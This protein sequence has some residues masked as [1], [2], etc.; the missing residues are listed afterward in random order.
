MKFFA[1]FCHFFIIFVILKK[2]IFRPLEALLAIFDN[3]WDLG[4]SLYY[5]WETLGIL[6]LQ[7]GG[8]RRSLVAL[9]SHFGLRNWF[10]LDVFSI[11]TSQ[12]DTNCQKKGLPSFSLFGVEAWFPSLKPKFHSQCVTLIVSSVFPIQDAAVSA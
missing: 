3:F 5:F 4:M 8:V 6:W 2:V 10:L 7:L 9:A 1:F 11:W 12:S